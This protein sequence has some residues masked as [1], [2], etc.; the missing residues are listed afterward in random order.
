MTRIFLMW[1]SIREVILTWILFVIILRNISKSRK[2]VFL[3]EYFPLFSLMKQIPVFSLECY[4]FQKE[5]GLFFFP[6]IITVMIF[7]DR[8]I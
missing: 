7:S 3:P 2:I 6:D 4:P 8:Q 1:T 5:S